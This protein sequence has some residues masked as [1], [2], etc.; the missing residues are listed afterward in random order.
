M[1]KINI[2]SMITILIIILFSFNCYAILTDRL[3]GYWSM[4]NV[5]GSNVID[6]IYGQN[7]GG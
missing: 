6:E 4:D 7:N 2:I 3:L 5:A 1:K